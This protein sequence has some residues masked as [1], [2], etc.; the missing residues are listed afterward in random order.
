MRWL[1]VILLFV[2]LAATSQERSVTL[3]NMTAS[4][5][6]YKYTGQTADALVPTTRDTIQY[7]IY[8]NKEYPVQY[9]INMNLAPVAGADTTVVYTL[10]GKV[11][12]GESWTQI[13]TGTTS[14]VTTTINS[15][16]SS[17]TATDYLASTLVFEA[18]STVSGRLTSANTASYYRYLMLDLQLS[19]NDSV[20]TG[21]KIN[22]LE[23]KIWRREF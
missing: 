11:F 18:D 17:F 13:A 6:Y 5:T 9:Y 16:I 2:S 3:P 12:A 15:P 10:Y 20:G 1:I 14:A 4:Q 19:G 22:N 23:F 8:L 7:T 21:V